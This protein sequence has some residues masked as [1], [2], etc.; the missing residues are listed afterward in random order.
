MSITAP[1]RSWRSRATSFSP[2]QRRRRFLAVEGLENRLLLA[3]V[4]WVSN[5]SGNWDDASNWN[6]D[7]IPGPGDDVVIDVNGATPTITIDSSTQATV[8]SLSASDPLAIAG[9]SLYVAADST[10]SGGLSMTAGG[11]LTASGSE[12]VLTVSGTPSI[13]AASL[14]ALDGANLSMPQLTSYSNPLIDEATTL[15][16]TGADSLLS[17][18]D[19]ASLGQLQSGLSIE[20]YV[21]GAV[22]L[23]SLT[24]IDTSQSMGYVDVAADGPGTTIDLSEVTSYNSPGSNLSVTGQATVLDKQLTSLTGV[25]VLLDG[26]GTMLT[27]Q[28]ASLTDGGLTINGGSYSLPGLTN[29][30]SSSLIVGPA[31]SLTLPGVINYANPDFETT[32]SAQGGGCVLSLPNL[33]SLG[34][35]QNGLSIAA[36]EGGAVSLPSLT[37]ID[38]SQSTG[39]VD[40]AADGRDSTIDLSDVTSYTCPA[41]SADLS[42]TSE[43]TVLDPKLTSLNG[44][45]VTLDGTGTIST[46]QW[47]SLTNGSLTVTG[48]IP[49]L[50]GLMDIDGSSLVAQ[51]G[52]LS[53]PELTSIADV[54]ITVSSGSITLPLLTNAVITNLNLGDG[55]TLNVPVLNNAVITSLNVDGRPTLSSPLLTTADISSLNLSDGATLSLPTLVTADISSLSLGSGSALSLPALAQGTLPLSNGQTV[56]I[57]GTVVSVPAAGASGAS[58]NVPQSQ[59]LTLTLQNSG[60]LTGTSFNV[61]P[62]TTVD[63]T[64]GTY[65]G[66]TT[67]DVGTG[68]TVDFTGGL[69]ATYGG[70]LTGSGDGSVQLSGGIAYIALGGVTLNFPGSMFQWTGGFINSALGDLTNL[71]TMNLAGSDQKSF[72]AGGTL[73]N[74][75]TITQIG[76]GDLD[77]PNDGP[78]TTTLTLEPGAL[79]QIEADSG[80]TTTGGS[81][82]V[83]N[84]GTIRKTAGSGASTIAVDGTISNTGTIEVDSG[85]LD[86]EPTSFSQISGSDLT[87][88]TWNAVGTAT[89]ELGGGAAITTSAAS[90]TES[91]ALA[92]ITGIG[93]LT[94]NTGSFTL[95]NGAS[96]TTTG[97]F[98]NSDSLTVGAASELTVSGNFTQTSAGTLDVQIGGTPASGLFGRVVVNG[99][100]TLAGAFKLTLVNGF[101]PSS[102]QDFEVM[103]FAGAPSAFTTF[104]GLN[105]FFTESLGATSLD[106]IDNATSAVDL[107]ATSVAAPTTATAGQAI[108]VSWQATD[109]SSQAATGSWQDSVYVSATP[110]ITSSSILLGATQHTGV[111]AAN[112][113]YT[114]SLTAALP[115][116]A[117]G[118]YY[119]LVQVDSL[120]QVADPNRANNTLAA[121]TGELAVSLPALTLGAPANGSFTTAG[122]DEYYQVTVPAGGALIVSL[123]SDASSGATA[124]YVSQGTEPTPYNYQEAADVANQPNQTVT[125]PQ[126]ATATTYYILAESIAGNAATAGYSLTATQTGTMSVSAISSYAGGNGGNVTIAINGTNFTRNTTASLSLEGAPINAAPIYYQNA[127]QIFATFN[128]AGAVIGSYTLTVKDGPNSATA[129]TKFNVVPA[130]TGEPLSLVLTPPSLVSA[131]RDS[132]VD[133]TATNTSNNDILAPLLQLTTDGSTLK[134]PSQTTFQGSTLYFLATSP[135]GP[136]GTLT[137]GESVQVEIQFQSTTTNPTINFQL[138]EADDSQLMDWASQE[139]ALQIPTIPDAA[140]PIVFGNFV[141]AMGSTVAQYH[142]VLAA[143]ATYL[144]QLGEPTNDV[145]QLLEFEIEKANAAYTAQTLVTVT[146]D[147]LPAPGMNLAF[148]QSYLAS[149]GGRYYQ[150]ILGAL[151]WTTNWDITATTTSTGDVAI[152]FSGSSFYFFLQTN[153]SYQPEAG[154]EGEVLTLTSG[155]Y[156]LL[157]PDGTVYQFNSNG[158]L[159]YVQDTNGNRI[160]ASYANGQLSQLTDTNGEYLKLGYNTQGQ[161]TTLTDSNGQ[162]ETY[163][164]TGQFLSSYQDIYGTTNYSYVSGGTAPQNGSLDE[165]AY[166]DNTHMY[167]TYDTE[168]RLIDQQRDGGAEDEKFSYLTPGGLVTTDGDGNKTTTLFDLYGATAETIDALGNVT[169]FNYDANLNLVQVVAPGGLTDSYSYDVNGNLT[170]QTDALGNTTVFA[171]NANNDLTSYTDAKGNTTSY[172]YDS[173]ENLLSVTYADG[174]SQQYNNYNPLGEA[175]QFVNANG[176]AIGYQYNADGLITQE[177]FADGTS[178]SY[179]YNAQGNLTQATDAQGNVTK[180]IYGNASNPTLLTEV[181]YPDGTWLKFAYNIV[182][183]RTQSVDQTGFTVNYQ[184]DAVGRL[185]ELTDGS[186]NLIV[187]YVYDSAGN[188]IQKDNGNGTFT[189]YTYDMDE[190]VASITNYAPSTGST[191]DEPAISAVNSFDKYTYDALGNVATDT[192]QDGQWVY[193]YDGDSQ[194]VHAVFTP[195]AADPDGLTA[196]N[197]QYVYD[198][199]GNRISETVNGVVTT[200]VANNVNEYTSSTT[201][202][203][204]TTYYSYDNDG[205][206]IK[207]AAPGGTT[208]Y[209]FDELNELTGVSGPGLT[210]SYA[211]NP[212]GE[213]VSQT[214]NGATTNYQID[215]AGLGNIVAAFSGAG[216]YNNSGGLVAHYTY[217]L[218]LISQV[219]P[220]GSAS[221]YDFDIT[222]NTVGISG[223]TGKYVNIYAYLPFGQTQSV[224]AAIVNPFSYTGQLG[225]SSNNSGLIYMRERNYNPSTGD[226]VS[227]DPLGL[228]G[229]DVNARRY[230]G[231]NPLEATDPT[232]LCPTPSIDPLNTIGNPLGPNSD[233]SDD[234][235]NPHFNDGDDFTPA[236]QTPEDWQQLGLPVLT[237]GG[238]DGQ[239]FYNSDDPNFLKFVPTDGSAPTY[240]FYSHSVQGD[241]PNDQAGV[242]GGGGGCTCECTSNSSPNSPGRNRGGGTT[243]N[244]T[245][246]DPNALIGPSGF[247]TQDFIAPSGNWSYT[248][249]FA[250]DGTAPALDVRATEQLDPSLDWST[251]QLGSFGFGPI[252]VTVPAGLTQYQTTV[253]YQNTDGS[254]LNVRVALDFNV[255]TGLLTVTLTSLD[256]ITGQAP[257]GVTDGFLPPDSSAGI[258]E[259][260][261]Q[262]TIEPKSN[263]TTGTAINQHAS[264]VFD[265]NAAIATNTAVNTIDTAVP[266]SSV[267]ALPA[268]ETSPSFSVSWSGSDGGGSGIASY[269]VYVSEDGG[270]FAPF[271]TDTTQTSATFTGIVGHSYSFYSVATSNVG[272][273]QPTP[274][275][276]QATTEVVTPPPP[277]PPPP[278][279]LVTMTGVHEVMNKK[280][281]VTEVLVTFSGALNPT[282]AAGT[283]IY[284]L[285]TAGKKGSY[286]AKNAGVIKI[287]KAV[288][289]ASSDSVALTAR[290]PFTLAKP[291]Q[292]QIT[293]TP[294]AGLQ[295]AEGRYIDGADN[296][297]SGSNAIAILSKRGVTI[298]AVDLARFDRRMSKLAAIDA[299]L[300][301]DELQVR[302]WPDD[303]PWLPAPVVL[304]ASDSR[305]GHRPALRS[306]LRLKNSRNVPAATAETSLGDSF[307]ARETT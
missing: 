72:Y 210:A 50:G 40:I 127:S 120:Y 157:E 71:G 139:Q 5:S 74:H 254:S 45:L 86:L 79:Y 68:A 110:T 290:K 206:L 298:A 306:F 202:G 228:R 175:M 282:E 115:G 65:T 190:R 222:G 194:L 232:G 294:P 188:L 307:R 76:S 1:R 203:V 191:P 299:L 281:Q 178:Y 183:Q 153:G 172:A 286:T 273:V 90:I 149:I 199:V 246:N 106:L 159:D 261:V 15:E 287:K 201:A 61:G 55:A 162:Q 147:D 129:P 145:L 251:F 200:Y 263:L 264:V 138:N 29:I 274:A 60:T 37:S 303:F 47:A 117:P 218:G 271:L 165:I 99:T 91:G 204:G 46:D 277:P 256:P 209:T 155:A 182:G 176:D 54:G 103:T 187:Q 253:A 288:Y 227:R 276:G 57:Q 66:A 213:Q 230:V 136:A 122:Q 262:Y 135:T 56:T 107:A 41:N 225:V 258:G 297:T 137:P 291:V 144:A 237:P 118:N 248:V 26:T 18:P 160:T 100:A 104:T 161:M 51:G 42:V 238:Q 185:Q 121:G 164:Y 49:N 2:V 295:D 4:T 143:D 220:G 243:P 24:S 116:L 260:Y 270:A 247:G 130:T 92:S 242:A 32:F 38:T 151:G 257:S 146:A 195:N 48:G 215:P 93:G 81:S 219:A 9:G 67:F 181:D 150:G 114:S 101:G 85:T 31:G 168:G 252:N 211:Y 125:V 196:Q 216:V 229:T 105:P 233:W 142:A 124:L 221:Y 23:P 77:L 141:A 25:S 275:A 207:T 96:F 269:N 133:V 272:F 250:N 28:W 166:S 10:I 305:H 82:A 268:T 249:E 134:L 123:A 11:S 301:R 21:G 35:L 70:T 22:S 245:A 119:V 20:A 236:S 198:A 36:S 179:V 97:D 44:V 173:S 113:T 17:L 169:L 88:G 62:G 193:T 126:V 234:P 73:D 184:Y 163:G 39:Y 140:W 244:Q 171:Y 128:L 13:S 33:A 180:F 289:T 283:T 8:N 284:R 59:G 132:V 174:T 94:S 226:F 197:L 102:A 189:V 148:Q 300:E 266:T 6:T 43:A 27:D 223:S 84:A 296:G 167:F 19:L 186:G 30:G 280:H 292:L 95:T 111:L 34:Q 87:G 16:A 177:N 293:G 192:S 170:S 58:I 83:D 131:G 304:P 302:L 278:P 12:V 63:L 267:A 52:S 241:P 64:G 285:A 208:T 205:N 156:R 279:P 214:V 80:I 154:D 235:N 109:Q 259:G 78:S 75:G 3:T 108:T 212:L 152:Q 14:Y 255:Q 217:G 224:A 158:S 231:N 239:W 98:T 112:G 265:I 7:T 53:L 240:T 89:L 69:F